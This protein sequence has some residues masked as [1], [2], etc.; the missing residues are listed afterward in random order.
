VPGGVSTSI[1]LG[2]VPGSTVHLG[3]L[4][5]EAHTPNWNFL[6]SWLE[7]SGL[8][9]AEALLAGQHDGERPARSRRA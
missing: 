5:G 4:L 8:V 9:G 1:A 6:R 2:T 3:S 7:A